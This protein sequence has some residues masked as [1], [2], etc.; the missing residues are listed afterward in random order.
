[1][2]IAPV[3]STH[4]TYSQ[5]L[6]SGVQSL[7]TSGPPSVQ[8][9]PRHNSMPSSPLPNQPA[10]PPT[11]NQS[12]SD[13]LISELESVLAGSA[14]DF[15]FTTP[16]PEK[17]LPSIP[18]SSMMINTDQDSDKLA[19]KTCQRTDF[20]GA[21][22]ESNSSSQASSQESAKGQNKTEEADSSPPPLTATFD[23][24]QTNTLIR[25]TLADVTHPVSF[26]N[27]TLSE[28][29]KSTDRDSLSQ[30]FEDI[31]DAED[32]AAA[33]AAAQSNS[34]DQEA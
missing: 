22:K 27:T 11:Q 19:K 7:P 30:L 21:L 29:A 33:A 28:P 3:E 23:D 1:M 31:T 24:G 13:F 10:P 17:L 25:S 4:V 2:S 26:S 16:S 20:L 18:P 8:A 9:D 15:T 5:Q 32:A 6:A 14:G 34:Q 12:S